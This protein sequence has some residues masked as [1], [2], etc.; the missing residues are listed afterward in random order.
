MK[1][2][3][4]III[5]FLLTMTA[6]MIEA[7]QPKNDKAEKHHKNNKKAKSLPPGLQKKLQRGGQLP[8]GWEKKL[9]RGAILD[10]IVYQQAIPIAIKEY[11]VFGGVI[12]GTV[13]VRVDNRILRLARATHEIIDILK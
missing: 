3:T 4:H 9:R 2:I 13:V 12:E 6:S 10:Q 5:L 8:P 1:I 7:D 11:K